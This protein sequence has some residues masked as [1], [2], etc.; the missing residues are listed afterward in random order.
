MDKV[1]GLMRNLDLSMAE[2]MGVRVRDDGCGENTSSAL[3]RVVGKLFFREAC[4][5][6]FAGTSFG[7]DLVSD[8][9]HRLQGSGR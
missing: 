3:V 6:R 4:A 9:G 2:R 5:S 1:E 8:A 7:Q